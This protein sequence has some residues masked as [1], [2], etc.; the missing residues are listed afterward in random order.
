MGRREEKELYNKANYLYSQQEQQQAYQRQQEKEALYDEKLERRKSRELARQEKYREI[1]QINRN[2]VNR[3]NAKKARFRHFKN[4]LWWLTGFL[5]FIVIAGGAIFGVLNYVKIKDI[6]GKKTSQIVS[7]EIADKTILQAVKGYKT[8]TLGDL[9]VIQELVDSLSEKFGIDGIIKIDFDK[10]NSTKIVSKSISEDLKDSIKIV[11]TLDSAGAMKYLG[12]FANL[13]SMNNFEKVDISDVPDVNGIEDFNNKLYYFKNANDKYERAF[14]DNGKRVEDAKGKDLYYPALKDVPILEIGDVFNDRFDTEK[15]SEV[16]K[17]LNFGEGN[18]INEIVGDKTIKEMQTFDVNTVKVSVFLDLPAKTDPDYDRVKSLYE[19]LMDANEIEYTEA[20]FRTKAEE[21]TIG[22]F[23]DMDMDKVSLT[24]VIDNNEENEKLYDVLLDITRENV[25]NEMATEKGISFEEARL[26]YENLSPAEK[27]KAITVGSLSG[28]DINKLKLTTVL[29]LEGNE[30]LYSILT[31]MTGVEPEIVTVEHLDG[32]EVSDIKLSN[33]LPIEGNG[34]TYDVLRDLAHKKIIDQLIYDDPVYGETYDSLSAEEK[35]LVRTEKE[36]Y[37][38]NELSTEEQNELVTIASLDG[39]D[40]TKIKLKTVM[41]EE[42]G[43]TILDK[44]LSKEEDTTVGNIG[45]QLND[46]SVAEIYGVK[47][48]ASAEEIASDL[49]LAP[50]DFEDGEVAYY[51]YDAI[52]K[53]YTLTTEELADSEKYYITKQSSI[54]LFMLYNGSGE[55][56][57]H[58]NDVRGFSTKY[59]YNDK[60]LKDIDSSISEMT[61]KI[62]NASIRQLVACGVLQDSPVFCLDMYPLTLQGALTA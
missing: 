48:F 50:F 52:E 5:S 4:F 2:K 22:A 19:L 8:Y 15:M 34:K 7:S 20:N 27:Q 6:A 12:S 49:S 13:N 28:A 11:A 60:K 55:N 25:I 37:Y 44:L 56:E 3:K 58:E 33:I 61:T 1:A 38:K 24:A 39:G 45:E 59:I 51:K 21:L 29:A 14:D 42:T 9:P 17:V 32:L 31:D 53:S 62:Q 57:M 40:I 10:L 47:V 26:E 41:G 16:L 46:L 54:W 35:A 23:T 36:N 18:S 43:N 30:K